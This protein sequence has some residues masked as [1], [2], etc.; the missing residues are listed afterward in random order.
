MIY[1]LCVVQSGDATDESVAKLTDTLRSTLN[2]F[3][4][5][6]MIQDNWGV[7]TFAQPTSTGKETGNYSYFIFKAN[8]GANKEIARRLKI[9]ETVLKYST[10]KLGEEDKTSELLKA[11]KTPLSKKYAGSALEQEEDDGEKRDRKRFT[12]SK[13]CFFKSNNIKADWKDPQTYSWLVNEFG[14]I[15][16][17]R[18]SGVSRK[19]QRFVTT[20]I[21]RARNLGIISHISSRTIS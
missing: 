4:G 8:S 20:A 11:Y 13:H 9:N 17:S 2:E 12:R 5:E 3:D 14:K 18:V 6:V 7:K 10:F 16:A 15:S 1:E 19:H 21:K